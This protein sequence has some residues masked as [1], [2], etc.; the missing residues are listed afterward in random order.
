MSMAT[1]ISTPIWRAAESRTCPIRVWLN[2]GAG[3]FA[4]SGQALGTQGTWSAALGD[5]D[6]DG[7]L[8]V[9]AGNGGNYGQ[10]DRIWLNNKNA[11]SA[12][13][14]HFIVVPDSV[15]NVLG[16]LANDSDADGDMLSL[17]AVGTP[18]YGGTAI[19][20]GTT[21]II[22]TP[23]T[24][25][26]GSEVFT[27]TVADSGGLT[28]SATVTVDVGGANSAPVVVDDTASTLEDVAVDIPVLANDHDPDLQT[29]SIVSVGTPISGSASIVGNVVHYA[30]ATDLYGLD[31]FDYAVSDGWLTATAHVT[32][33][34]TSVEDPP[35]VDAHPD[36]AIPE[37]APTQTI[38][39]TG[40]SS[41]AFN[42]DQ[43]LTVTVQRTEVAPYAVP[44]PTVVYTSPDTTADLVFR[45]T[46]DEFGVA[47]LTVAVSD[48]LGTTSVMFQV[49]ITAVNDPPQFAVPVSV[50]VAE[51]VGTQNVPLSAISYGPTNENAQRPA[52][53]FTA[54]STNPALIPQPV[55]HYD[56]G[57]GTYTGGSVSITPAPY[58]PGTATIVVTLTDGLSTTVKSFPVTVVAVNDPPT[59][60][61][62]AKLLIKEDAPA[63]TIDLSGI[64]PGPYESEAVTV[65]AASRMPT[66]VPQPTVVYTNPDMTGRLILAP[67]PDRNGW[68][69]IDVTVTDGLLSTVRT[70]DVYVAPVNDPPTLDAIGGQRL[71]Q[72]GPAIAVGLAGIGP[73][74][75]ESQP[76][77]V[78]AVVADT[79]LVQ[80]AVV[81]YASPAAT[82]TITLTPTGDT[83]G[84]T[85]VAISVTDGLSV[86]TRFF[87]ATVHPAFR[88]FEIGATASATCT[89]PIA[90]NTLTSESFIVRGQQNGIYAGA[91]TVR[92][93]PHDVFSFGVA[94]FAPQ[95]AFTAS[96]GYRPGDIVE[97]T[98]TGDVQS[99]DGRTLPAYTWQFRAPVAGGTGVFDRVDLYPVETA[100]APASPEDAPPGRLY[101][102]SIVRPQSVLDTQ[103][104]ALGD[105]DG[106]GDLDG[107]V[108]RNGAPDAVWLNDGTGTFV[109]GGQ[110]LGLAR[111]WAVALGDL[112]GDGD[113]DAFVGNYGGADTIWLN[114]T[115]QG[116]AG[117]FVDSGQNLGSTDTYAVVLLDVDHDGD[118]DAVTGSDVGQPNVLWLNDGGLQGGTP[119]TFVAGRTRLG[120]ESVRALATGDFDRDGDLDLFL[121]IAGNRPNQVWLNEAGVFVD[122]GQRLGAADTYAV[123]TGDLDGDGDVDAFVGNMDGQPNEVW[124]NEAGAFVDSGRRLGARAT[125]AVALGDVD[126]DG[127]LDAFVGN[128]R[129]PLVTQS[130]DQI[131]TNNGSGVFANT[132]QALGDW[133]TLSV[134]LGDLDGDGDLDALTGTNNGL[135]APN[136]VWRNR[137]TPPFALDDAFTVLADATASLNVLRG[138][139]DPEGSSLQVSA[140]GPPSHGTA[141]TDGRLVAYS[142]APGFT[143]R[144]VFTYTA[145]DA[146]GLDDAAVVAL[147][148]LPE[149]FEIEV[150]PTVGG[151]LIHADARGYPT[152]VEIPAGAVAVSTTVGC[153]PIQRTMASGV[154]G[155]FT[156]HAFA[157]TAGRDEAP[158][159]PI[160]FMR[161]LTVT[162]AYGNDEFADQDGVEVEL[163]R[164]SGT[165][166][167]SDGVD[168]LDADPAL[169]QLVVQ[170][171]QTGEY[172]LFDGADRGPWEVFLPLLRRGE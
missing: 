64:G 91:R 66:V 166:W 153:V 136:A 90:G 44:V 114:Q 57:P 8:D 157:L 26:Y 80:S 65:T 130:A 30:P 93:T 5:L 37:D 53:A 88:V 152:V 164:W 1:A 117:H 150:G 89:R 42:E 59:L 50:T 103:A 129:A 28:A 171:S 170:V 135:L 107:Y 40:I 62:L 35:T 48:G 78:G 112:D 19:L 159:P 47:F 52:L 58:T 143:G 154:L 81:G 168:V 77:A 144:D 162:I 63:Q 146:D 165:A 73:G 31:H 84:V 4:D 27:Y 67:A 149:I 70:F 46:P 14:D 21:H 79:T 115:A 39:I 17:L 92:L 139:V 96:A 24:G 43:A 104:V 55:I 23:A 167:I 56:N 147:N 106:D 127:D 125:W 72:D 22:Y 151:V 126:A 140:L 51:N 68:A 95:T 120:Y 138:D 109:D 121:G 119:G 15:G 25:Y 87:D 9:F 36:I 69:T 6:G 172:A 110:A 105:L 76:L 34:V 74:P 18:N 99:T 82:G 163:R 3:G 33:T 7:D 85:S 128:A 98:L 100:A 75:Y 123:A 145:R 60:D 124:L 32:V 161:P 133:D 94:D 158:L 20:S 97:A 137:P 141:T 113:L 134:A 12:V 148:V 131:W 169:G 156:G 29:L 122:S 86:T 13:D 2:D 118:L 111:S 41:G 45:P 54:S 160:A 132:G 71:D 16:V 108:V 83:F 142:P 61:A 11:P 101:N 102:S 155:G 38:H 49:D 116:Q 10:P